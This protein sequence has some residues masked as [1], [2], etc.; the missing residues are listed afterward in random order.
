MVK[1]MLLSYLRGQLTVAAIIGVAV[2]IALA[3]E[4][5][6]FAVALGVLAGITTLVPF[7]GPWIGAVPWR[8]RRGRATRRARRRCS[9]TRACAHG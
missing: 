1:A 5:M 3:I 2:G 9:G 8:L 4:G 6:P 7:I